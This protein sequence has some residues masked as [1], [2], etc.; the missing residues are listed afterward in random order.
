M[1]RIQ[2]INPD[3]IRW[4]CDDYDVTPEKLADHLKISRARFDA[5]MAGEDGLTSNQIRKIAKYFNRGVLFF[6]E[7]GPVDENRV[8]SAQF[9][10][11]ANERPDLS[12][13][14]KAIIERVETHRDLFLSLQ[15]DL[16][17]ED[18]VGFEPPDVPQ[19]SPKRAAAIVR[20]WLS[21]GDENSFNSYREAIEAKRVLVFRSIGYRGA[22]RIPRKSPI[23]GFSVYH[24]T[25]PV[26][27]IKKQ[28]FDTR[29]SFTLMHE[30][31]HVVLHRSSF[32]DDDESLHSR[33]GRER[34]AN[35]FAG[36]L[37]VPDELL[38]RIE[39]ES[40]PNT[41]AGYDEWASEYRNQWGVSTE[42]ILRRMLDSGALDQT[43]YQAYRDWRKRQPLP[44]QSGGSRQY[45]AREPLH[46]FGGRFV[47]TVLDALHA[48]Q[49]TLNK[50]S[51]YLDNL[52]VKD[53]RA[54]EAYVA[55]I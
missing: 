45:R 54:L 44:E 11:I 2:E 28:T 42:V 43:A 14:L 4:C 15:E 46:I 51:A 25:C 47:R 3:R 16:D 48:R 9:R 23:V 31:A 12:P 55:A 32:I 24:E 17:E 21:L 30:L 7:P 49:I 6:L 53:V 35:S 22:W 39:T 20:D 33:Q 13:E 1:S 36:H 10:T 8:R 18:R 52:K 41:V 50:A 26:I 27:L 38:G 34:A 37:L 19:R 29:Q 5:M 40:L